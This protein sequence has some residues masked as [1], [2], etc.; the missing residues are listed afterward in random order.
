MENQL[1]PNDDLPALPNVPATDDALDKANR[2]VAGLDDDQVV[3][4]IGTRTSMFGRVVT[5]LLIVGVLGLGGAWYVRDQAYQA[6]WAAYDAAQDTGDQAQFLRLIREELP[7]AQ[8]DDVRMRI[9]QK[10]GQYRDAESVPVLIP[11]LDQEGRMRAHAARALAEIGSPAADS[12]KP[13]LLR[14]L[15][16]TDD[17][18]R[19]PVVWALAVLNEPAAADAIIAEFENGRLQHQRHPAF[20]PRIVVNAVG[21]QRLSAPELTGHESVAVRTLVAQA[22]SEAGTP[23]VI[24]PLSRMI[25]DAQNTGEEGHNVLRIA[26]AGLGR[27]GD[28]RAATPLFQLMQRDPAMRVAVLEALRR[29]TGA[30]GLTVLLGSAGD[31]ATKR[32]LVVMLRATHDPAAADALA[33]MLASEDEMTRTE[34]AHGLAELGDVRAAPALL[35]IAQATPADAGRNALDAM[36]SLEIPAEI[37]SQLVPMLS[38]DAFLNRRS[39]VMRVL[40]RARSRDAETALVRN[41]EGDDIASAA[42]ALADM[43]SDAGYTALMR[44]VPRGRDQDFAQYMGM[45]GVPL[46]RE[47]DNRTAAV[48]AIGRYGRV[49]AAE[50]MM[51]IIEDPQDDIRLRNDAGLALGAIADDAVLQQVLAKVQQTDLDEAARRYYL[52]ALWQRPSRAMSSA[53]LDLIASPATPPDVRSPAAVAVGYAADPANDAR[54]VQMLESDQTRVAA[55]LAIALGG[56]DEAAN[57]LVTRLQGDADLRQ[58]LQDALMNETNDWFN[59]ITSDLW[60]SGQV[61]RRIRVARILNEGGQGFAW[62]PLMSRLRSGWEGTHGLSGRDVRNRFFAML[63]GDDADQRLLAA[64]LLG[65]MQETGLLMAARDQGGNGAEEARNVLFELNRPQTEG[66]EGAEDDEIE[67]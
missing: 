5:L 54:L 2:Q 14:V 41:L 32:D 46:Q 57:A 27:I 15:P 45:A 60:D 12:A 24:D 49:D 19:A 67:G 37:A 64:R 29:S 3:K 20:D 59:L 53:L 10:M 39:S 63:R 30:R 44:I 38:N 21:V 1:E 43:G 34:A 16:Q 52:G 35:A 50:A 4:K 23:D 6:R 42:L 28:P 66:D 18:D 8:F 58:V 7:R 65:D 62:V 61:M 36:L 51:T 56:S 25:L 48:R 17:R 40:G 9:M 33:G 47:Y 26:A 55:A 22:L 13:H 11:F 31:A